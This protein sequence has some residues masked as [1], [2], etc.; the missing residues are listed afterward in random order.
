MFQKH[1]GYGVLLWGCTL[2]THFLAKFVV[3]KLL[4]LS[5]HCLLNNLLGYRG[6]VGFGEHDDDGGL[7]VY[8]V[9]SNS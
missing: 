3:I 4:W 7:I 2:L 8:Q 9:N 6:K 5:C 1:W